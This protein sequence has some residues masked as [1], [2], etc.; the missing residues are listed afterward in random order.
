[1]ATRHPRIT[2]FGGAFASLMVMSI[3]SAAMGRVILGLIPAVSPCQRFRRLH[4]E[5]DNLRACY[6]EM[7]PLRR[8]FFVADHQGNLSSPLVADQ[9]TALSHLLAQQAALLFLV[10]G[11]RMFQEG[12][13][14]PPGNAHI[15]EEMKEVEDELEEEEGM[16]DLEGRSRQIEMEEGRSSMAPEQ[17]GNGS[18]AATKKSLSITPG[19]HSHQVFGGNKSHPLSGPSSSSSRS[20]TRAGFVDN[21]RSKWTT[22]RMK[23]STRNLCSLFFS[24]VFAQAFILT[25]LGEWGDRS[26]I[27]TIALGGANVSRIS[28]RTQRAGRLK[29][30]SPPL[31]RASR[32]WHLG[33]FLVMPS[34]PQAQ[35]SV[36]GFFRRASPFVTVSSIDRPFF[37]ARTVLETDVALHGLCSHPH[38]S[39]SILGVRRH[40][41]V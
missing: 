31:R 34:A 14:I 20:N 13:A 1:M 35:S 37:S 19:R 28:G 27:A 11:I 8:E 12:L 29:F 3:L 41:P 9:L 39:R 6:T 15:Q 25:F 17:E 22:K 2:V 38:W 21:L 32:S 36:A 5:P 7:D 40:V 16:M 24:P 18:A 4:F 30:I 33:R 26:Q 10:F 23:D